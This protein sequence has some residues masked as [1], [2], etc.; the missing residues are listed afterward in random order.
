MATI[1]LTSEVFKVNSSDTLQFIIT[2][3]KKSG[4]DESYT[5]LQKNLIVVDTGEL[6]QSFSL[7][8]LLLVP[9]NYS[10]KI[11]DKDGYLRGLIFKNAYVPFD[12]DIYKQMLEVKLNGVTEFKGYFLEDAL[13]CDNARMIVS[14]KASSDIEILN[15]TSLYGDYED[16]AGISGDDLYYN[17]LNPLGYTRGTIYP[18]GT[19]LYDIFKKINPSLASN[20]WA[21]KLSV[22]PTDNALYCNCD[23]LYKGWSDIINSPD[24]VT[25]GLSVDYLNVNCSP[26]FF[27]N[28]A[29][30]NNLG[31]IL[32]QISFDLGCYTGLIGNVK[33]FMKQLYKYDSVNAQSLGVVKSYTYNYKTNL[34]KYVTCSDKYPNASGTFNYEEKFTSGTLNTKD[35]R[36]I[37]KTNLLSGWYNGTP[38]T[39]D[40]FVQTNLTAYYNNVGWAIF[41]AYDEFAVE[42][43]NVNQRTADFWYY[44]RSKLEFNQIDSFEVSGV[45]YSFIRD[46]T[47]NGY[48][49]QIVSIRKKFGIDATEIEAINLGV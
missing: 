33:P 23:R 13:S 4:T 39:P 22:S 18:I 11:G 38:G 10:F 28:A 25:T 45:N 41:H 26:M 44:Y 31:D 37:E 49:Y 30:F 3:T 47:Y 48:K 21:N 32:R 17:A 29:G 35:A 6:E 43:I 8:D 36:K 27:N 46:F 1:T 15:D 16:A 19:I 34:I 20:V 9:A 42:Y 12:S 5:F 40:L 14:L 24:S 2:L 7:D